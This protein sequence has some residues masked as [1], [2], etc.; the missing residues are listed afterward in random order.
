MS[1]DLM[2]LITTPDHPERWLM[3][4]LIP[5]EKLVRPQ[6]YR[7]ITS[8]DGPAAV[9]DPFESDAEYEEFLADFN[10]YRRAGLAPV[11]PLSTPTSPPCPLIS[12]SSYEDTHRGMARGANHST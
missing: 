12:N 3:D 7:S 8:A 5:T 2:F 1:S 11:S 4:D 10:A 9:D 6:G